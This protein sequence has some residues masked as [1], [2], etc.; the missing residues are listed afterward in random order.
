[1]K[2]Q[3]LIYARVKLLNPPSGKQLYISDD[4]KQIF[5]YNQQEKVYMYNDNNYEIKQTF[6]FMKT[7]LVSE[8]ASGWYKILLDIDIDKINIVLRQPYN[9]NG[10]KH[11]FDI[12]KKCYNEITNNYI[13]HLILNLYE[14]ILI[15]RKN[16]NDFIEWFL[17]ME[18]NTKSYTHFPQNIY[19]IGTVYIDLSKGQFLKNTK[20]DNVKF[21]GGM[22]YDTTYSWI[23][24][25][26]SCIM[27]QQKTNSFIHLQNSFMYSNCT[28][29]I[30]DKTMCTY[31]MNKIS[32]NN[33]NHSIKIINIQ[34]DHKN[35]S[36]N[37]LIVFDYL[38]IN[39]DYF[40]NKKYISVIDDY[41]INNNSLKEIL[42]IIKEEF[43]TFDNIKNKTDVILSL[44]K[45]NRIIID[46]ASMINF[47]KDNY[48]FELLMT[49][50]A[51]NKWIHMDKMP[52]IH[53]NYI[54]IFKFIL[55]NSGIAFPLYEN[56]KI[57][58][59]NNIM[60]VFDDNVKNN[61]NIKEKSVF[62]KSG[63]LENGIKNYADKSKININKFYEIT[64]I[65]Y[66]N[67]ISRQKY[68]NMMDIIG[69]NVEF[70]NLKC[71][72]CYNIFNQEEVLFTKCGHYYCVECIL[73]N[74]EYNNDCPLC[75]RSI[76]I[77][78]LHYVDD[79]CNNDKANELLKTIKNINGKVYIYINLLKSKKYLLSYLRNYGIG[80]S[81]EWLYNDASKTQLLINN[82]T[83]NKIDIIFYDVCE[84]IDEIKKYLKLKN[85]KNVNVYYL[86]YDILQ[87]KLT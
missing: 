74:L 82:E 22:I 13:S 23:D 16:D 77:K 86:F 17:L 31:W 4:C 78:S 53:N 35:I 62:V 33:K 45:W 54:S 28:L 83:G 72:I 9:I 84:N 75:R 11:L 24:K 26:I 1:M 8:G 85:F 37:D 65:L 87:D 41:N 69:M 32:M 48:A 25:I 38:I 58:Y 39:S 18:S 73:E 68:V 70:N 27:N 47:I 56:S 5:Y 30:C 19:K 10:R 34:K 42:K 52:T 79:E 44:I 43:Q 67:T 51:N 49:L 50:E 29:I 36:Y 64:N 6:D 76:T 12:F 81:I 71:S 7:K 55:S 46:S 2:N 59:L 40:I 3:E 57:I 21:N 66:E 60:Y 80:N 63:K 14:D 61:I 15:K 20:L